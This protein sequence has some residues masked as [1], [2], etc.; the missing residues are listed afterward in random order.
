MWLRPQRADTRVII[1]RGTAKAAPIC[2]AIVRVRRKATIVA[3]VHHL[4]ARTT[5]RGRQW[6]RNRGVVIK[7][8]RLL[9]E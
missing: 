3:S 5:P 2:H 7:L 4:L 1:D 6:T 8:H 9:G